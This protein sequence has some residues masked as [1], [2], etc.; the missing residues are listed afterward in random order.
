[1]LVAV[2][3]SHRL[4][5]KAT[6]QF[7]AKGKCSENFF[8]TMRSE[9]IRNKPATRNRI[10]RMRPI[11]RTEVDGTC[12]APNHN[13][14]IYRSTFCDINIGK[15]RLQGEGRSRLCADFSILKKKVQ[16]GFVTFTSS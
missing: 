9:A 12:G 8:A 15:G 3:I 14:R 5:P 10:V 2:I 13:I 7:G 1:M 6:A 16:R 4:S 11:L